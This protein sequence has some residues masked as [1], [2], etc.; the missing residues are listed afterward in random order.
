MLEEALWVNWVADRRNPET[1]RPRESSQV[2]IKLSERRCCREV[3]SVSENDTPNWLT[4]KHT[5]THKKNP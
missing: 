2:T 3:N 1:L 4:S 5:H